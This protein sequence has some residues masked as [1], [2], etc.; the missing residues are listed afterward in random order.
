MKYR[1]DIHQAS[2]GEYKVFTKANIPYYQYIEF[3]RRVKETLEE[4]GFTIF[5]LE[6]IDS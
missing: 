1:I 3:D 5:R 6:G 2:N 4:N